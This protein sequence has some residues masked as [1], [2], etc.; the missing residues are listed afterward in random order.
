MSNVDVEDV[1]CTRIGVVTAK[2]RAHA[3][4][5]IDRLTMTEAARAH[6]KHTSGRW[7]EICCGVA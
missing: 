7:T 1:T 6:R 2:A 5:H 3:S 4:P